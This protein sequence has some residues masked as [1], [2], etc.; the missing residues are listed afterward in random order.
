[1]LEFSNDQQR[2]G[3]QWNNG[4]F[5]SFKAMARL[6][7]C[8]RENETLFAFVG[9][10]RCASHEDGEVIGRMVSSQFARLVILHVR[11]P[12][13]HHPGTGSAGRCKITFTLITR[14]TRISSGQR[15]AVYKRFD[16]QDVCR[17]GITSVGSRRSRSEKKTAAPATPH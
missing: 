10:S 1:V 14:R 9:T 4:F 16:Q 12:Q 2:R 7:K 5:D 17:S 15:A 8:S 3:E 6:G 13:F 11:P